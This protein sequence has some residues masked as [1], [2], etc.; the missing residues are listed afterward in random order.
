[1]NKRT[2]IIPDDRRALG[3]HAVAIVG[4]DERGFWI[5]NSWGPMWGRGGLALLSYDDWIAHALDV[6]VVQLGVATI[7]SAKAPRPGVPL[8]RASVIGAG[9]PIVAFDD[10]GRLRARGELAADAAAIGAILRRVPSSAKNKRAKDLLLYVPCGEL[11]ER[12]VAEECEAFGQ[13]AEAAG[14][15]PLSLV[16]TS[17]IATRLDNI[18][19]EE[20]TRRGATSAEEAAAERWRERWDDSLE[21]LVRCDGT[22]F[23]E[24]VKARAIA[25]VKES[26]GGAQIAGQQIA[27]LLAEHPRTRLHI[28]C[29]G[30]GALQALQLVQYLTHRRRIA[31]GPLTPAKGLSLR[32]STLTLWRPACSIHLFKRVIGPAVESSAVGRVRLLTASRTEARRALVPELYSRSL[33]CLISAAL[34]RAPRR[35]RALFGELEAP[36]VPLLGI[37]EHVR[38]DPMLRAWFQ[39]RG[40]VFR[41]VNTTLPPSAFDRRVA[42]RPAE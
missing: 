1:V 11:D 37:A 10:R 4:Y 21:A 31:A 38:R 3:H 7:V 28:V 29:H 25:A 26:T 24:G 39:K 36:G 13:S 15:T 8:P 40:R 27:S 22:R 14:F 17:G 23:W 2:G 6:W 20:L 16:W 5:Q 19:R 12:G 32:V 35:S 34:E 42:L 30:T 9:P 41:D 33:L 18:M